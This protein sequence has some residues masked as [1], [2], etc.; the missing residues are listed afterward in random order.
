MDS[1]TEALQRGRGGQAIENCVE[2]RIFYLGVA[3][4]GEY[5]N[6]INPCVDGL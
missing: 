2:L 3:G 5:S 6:V 1:G 4:A